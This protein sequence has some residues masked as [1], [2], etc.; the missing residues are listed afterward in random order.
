VLQAGEDLG[1]ENLP[2]DFPAYWGALLKTA[3]QTRESSGPVGEKLQAEVAKRSRERSRLRP[4]NRSRKTRSAACRPAN[5]LSAGSHS[6]E[7]RPD[8]A[9][10]GVG[11]FN[12]HRL[13]WRG[14]SSSVLVTVFLAWCSHLMNPRPRSSARFYRSCAEPHHERATPD[15]DTASAVVHAE[16]GA[17][18][19]A[20]DV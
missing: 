10:D 19:N 4:A 2:I 15:P 13:Q 16:M 11:H 20:G 8:G 5:R 14:K 1:G 12:R 7:R 9:I 18:D 3:H 6:L 17:L